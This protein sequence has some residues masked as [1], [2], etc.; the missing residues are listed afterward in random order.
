MVQISALVLIALPINMFISVFYSIPVKSGYF[1]LSD[2]E[3]SK[4]KYEA[5][6]IRKSNGVGMFENLFSMSVKF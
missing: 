2:E 1:E 4:A 3:K 5:K 6:E